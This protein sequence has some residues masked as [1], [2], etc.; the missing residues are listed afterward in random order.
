MSG[1]YTNSHHLTSGVL[2][3]ECIYNIIILLDPL[4]LCL[5][6]KHSPAY[7]RFLVP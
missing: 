1:C 4:L 6:L 3:K 7:T 2:N 5:K